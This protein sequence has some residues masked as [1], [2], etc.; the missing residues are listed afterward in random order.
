MTITELELLINLVSE[1]MPDAQADNIHEAYLFAEKA[2]E[3]QKR[4]SGKAYIT[5]PVA[6]AAITA[7]LYQDVDTVVASLLHDTIEDCDVSEKDIEKKF[8]KTVLQLVKSVTK[9]NQLSFQSK[10][11]EQAENYRKMMVAM[12]KDIRVIVIKLADRLHNIRTL[13]FVD[14]DKQLRIAKETMD[15]YAP[16]ANR[17]GM[18]SIKWELEDASFSFLDPEGF[19]EIKKLVVSKRAEREDYIYFLCSEVK[20]LLSESN[21]SATIEGRPKHFW[22]IFKKLQSGSTTFDALYDMLGIRVIVDE[23]QDCYIVLGFIHSKYIPVPS[24]F[25]DYIAVPKSNL[26]QSLHT[27]ILGPEGKP[28]EVQIRTR[29]MHKIAEFGIAA[30]WK[31]KEG[32][33]SIDSDKTF[34]WLRNMMEVQKE[35]ETSLDFMTHLKMDF[36]QEEVFVFTPDGDVKV[37]IQGATALDFAFSVHTEVGYRCIGVKVNGHMSSL[38]YELLNGDQIEVLTSKSQTPHADWLTFVRTSKAKSRIKQWLKIQISSRLIESGKKLLEDSIKSAGFL[39]GHFFESNVYSAI[40]KR[41]SVKDTNHL[42][43]L[44]GQGDISVKEIIQKLAPKPSEDYSKIQHK[45]IRKNSVYA[46]GV[47]VAGETGISVSYAKC[48]SPLPG[49]YIEGIVVIGKGV[50]IHRSDCKNITS[51]DPDKK[52]RLVEV[53]WD[54]KSVSEKDVFSA[55][56]IV[57]AFDRV[58]VMQEILRRISD[59]NINMTEL[60]TLSNQEDGTMK[61]TLFLELKHSDELS[62]IRMRLEAISD[63]Y[64]VLRG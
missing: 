10:E 1:Y 16:L 36:F 64:S 20:K 29:E 2:H 63:V 22:S 11:D 8:G 9:L 52:D 55:K 35:S 12:A 23:T 15:I 21:I 61:A 24:R 43:L 51:L 48:C 27:T 19:Q 47:S 5:H 60:I 34:S 44:L 46:G 18:A 32:R 6:V 41:Y 26:Y 50:S 31:Y 40:C 33:S 57:E 42:F 37:L 53:E 28:V 4:D 62:K 38:S 59:M 39:L 3:G 58:G 30:H 56:I 54:L 49:D 17:I 14:R 7:E 13:K 45:I 25:K